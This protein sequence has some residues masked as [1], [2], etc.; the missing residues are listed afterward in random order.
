MNRLIY[1]LLSSKLGAR[2]EIQ[3]LMR[4]TAKAFCEDGILRN[5]HCPESDP[6]I[7]GQRN[8]RPSARISAGRK[9]QAF[10]DGQLL[11]PSVRLSKQELLDTYARFTADAARRAIDSGQDMKQLH[12]RLYCMAR[13][14]GT[15]LRR[16][17]KPENDQE[18]QDIIALLYR[19][20]GINIKESSP[21]KFTVQKCYFST[22]YTPDICAVI[23]AIDQGIFAGIYG[24]GRLTFRERITEGRNTCKA[25]FFGN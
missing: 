9:N 10:G 21:G 4:Q 19:N 17:L 18:C 11:H 14:L 24:R 20:I 12:H 23:S 5:H 7:A 3:I 13:Q 8:P 2:L 22:F 1:H 6:R 15:Q 25:Y 16:W